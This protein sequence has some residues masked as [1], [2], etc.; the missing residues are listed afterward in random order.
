MREMLG[1]NKFNRGRK[2]HNNAYLN[3]N[4]TIGQ[5]EDTRGKINENRRETYSND[6][7]NRNNNV[8]P[9]TRNSKAR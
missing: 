1:G 6:N 7:A 8:I 9:S 2:N 4:S 5:C 3:G